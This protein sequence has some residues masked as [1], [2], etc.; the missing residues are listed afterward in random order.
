MTGNVVLIKSLFN[1][2]AVNVSTPGT[3]ELF[4]RVT[5]TAEDQ[6]QEPSAL[7]DYLDDGWEIERDEREAEP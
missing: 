2:I 7:L 3:G 1:S 4:C 6:Q 5:L